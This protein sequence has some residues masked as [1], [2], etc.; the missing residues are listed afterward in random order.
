[1][2]K[3]IAG[4][5]LFIITVF[6]SACG[7]VSKEEPLVQCREER[8]AYLQEELPE[9]YNKIGQCISYSVRQDGK[10][11]LLHYSQDREDFCVTLYSPEESTYTPLEFTALE[12]DMGFVKIAVGGDGTVI[13]MTMVKMY[14]H[15]PEE[16]EYYASSAALPSGGLWFPTESEMVCQGYYELPYY[17]I[18]LTTGK[19]KDIFLDTDFLWQKGIG[20]SFL[21]ENE[22]DGKLYVTTPAG[23]YEYEK[24][25]QEWIL[26][27]TSEKTSLMK[28]GFEPIEMGQQE[29]GK[30]YICDREHKYIYTPMTKKEL[31]EQIVLRVV[32]WQD[33]YTLK[34][35][36]AEYQI[37]HPEITIDYEF[38]CIDLPKT[39][40]EANPLLQKLNLEILS[41]DAADLYIL[42]NLP[43]E[44]YQEKGCLMD[45]TELVKPYLENNNYYNNILTAY[46]SEQGLFTV[47]WFFNAQAVICREEAEA[48]VGNIDTLAEY[49]KKNP[50]EMPVPYFFKD[51]PQL[52]LRAMYDFYSADLMENGIYTQ[53]SIEHFL[54]SA[55]VIYERMMENKEAEKVKGKADYS[56]LSQVSTNQ[57]YFLW[58]EKQGSMAFVYN[59]PMGT[60]D[61]PET[62][63]YSDYRLVPAGGIK[64]EFLMGIH[65]KSRQKEETGRLFQFLME[66]MAHYDKED[67][68]LNVFCFLPGI[69]VAK[70]PLFNRLKN[71]ENENG[72]EIC[73][74]GTRYPIHSVTEKEKTQLIE[75]M[76]SYRGYSPKSDSTSNA[77][78]LA[79]EESG[80]RYIAGEKG[81]KETAEELYSKLSLMQDEK[82]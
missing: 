80:W 63:F 58:K 66:Y 35:A 30:Y 1:M 14:L 23:L 72:K 60:S 51:E 8:E 34:T 49:L 13:L 21:Y 26:R 48:Y 40:Q 41:G 38:Q 64:G 32:A 70:Q 24:E 81:L 77:V 78:Y 9:E 36:L 61:L 12:E 19:K 71:A 73:I 22:E 25:K 15:H 54:S 20:K 76:E 55:R 47:P 53:E 6:L 67:S 42:D 4:F 69:P 33:R 28:P 5:L 74:E 11:Y 59:A 17:V 10:V 68:S 75:F 82:N 50:E 46:Q 2:K 7:A 62:Y 27:V 52:F 56:D 79:L 31:E 18:D 45:L 3:G 44:S 57:I 37:L 16:L 65:A 29:D 39:P 43:W